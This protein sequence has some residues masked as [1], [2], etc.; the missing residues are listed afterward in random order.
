MITIECDIKITSKDMSKKNDLKAPFPYFG[1]K[2]KIA[3]KVWEKLGQPAHYME[4]FFGSGAVLL[5]R[6]GWSSDS[7]Y[8]E[9]ICDKDGFVANVWRSIKYAPDKVAEWCDW[10][11][12]H[13]DLIARK[14]Y[15]IRNER[16]L[17]DNLTD[18]PEWYDYK[19]AGYW[20][21]GASCWI[22]SS[23][24]TSRKNVPG[25]D[26]T[27]KGVHKKTY[28]KLGMRAGQIP[29]LGNRGQGVVK[30]NFHIYKTMRLLA[31]RLRRVRV[32]CGDW[33]RICGGNWQHR[34]WK[35]VGIFFDPPYCSGGIARKLYRYEDKGVSEKVMQW[36][37]K[38]SENKKYKIVVAGYE[39][40]D[41]LVKKHGWTVIKWKTNGGMTNLGKNKERKKNR[42]RERLYCSPSCY[43]QKNIFDTV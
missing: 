28:H 30:P 36:C 6:P 27:G 32:V 40:Y 43:E 13:A 29:F 4:P 20:I 24:I 3:H 12:N 2:S 18:D 35:T 31:D 21:W 19:L 17:I 42:H 1:G 23:A 37:I 14:G 10:P 41:N 15:L 9:T 5:A 33:T 34:N 38:R 39:E 7:D 16:Y 22:G 25:I 26:N 11:V 8:T